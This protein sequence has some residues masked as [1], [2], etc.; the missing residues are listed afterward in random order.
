MVIELWDMSITMKNDEHEFG[1]DAEATLPYGN[2]TRIMPT[3]LTKVRHP[4]T[5]PVVAVAITISHIHNNSTRTSMASNPITIA[6][7]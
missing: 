3:K 6:K 1:D 7:Q 4:V 2:L 5:M